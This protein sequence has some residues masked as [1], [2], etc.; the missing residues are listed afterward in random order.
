M[1]MQGLNTPNATTSRSWSQVQDNATG[2]SST[3]PQLSLRQAE[4]LVDAAA[5]TALSLGL[6]DVEAGRKLL[7]NLPRTLLRAM[8]Q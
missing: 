8:L 6:L 1:I 3:M 5:E 7:R 2:T 4:V